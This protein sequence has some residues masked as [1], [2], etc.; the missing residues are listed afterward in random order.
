[1]ASISFDVISLLPKAFKAL[2]DM[3]VISRAI[4]KDLVSINV[5]NL[6]DFGEGSYKQVD[7]LPYGGGSGMLLKPEPI[8]NAYESIKKSKNNITLLMTPQGK[9][10]EQNDFLRWLS[11]EVILF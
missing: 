8:Y 6:R 9:V 1:M 4:K 5:C 11:Y 3:G 2:D 7:D 10:L